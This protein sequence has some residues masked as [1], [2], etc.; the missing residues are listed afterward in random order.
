MNRLS[1]KFVVAALTFASGVL[2]AAAVSFPLPGRLGL[3]VS[4][5]AG[6]VL[7]FALAHAGE[8]ARRSQSE[9]AVAVVLATL[10]GGFVLLAAGVWLLVE[11][12]L[13]A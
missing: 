1:V 2:C 8:E 5:L 9:A 11:A 6:S 7:C 10:C 4:A 13:A 12:L 3:A